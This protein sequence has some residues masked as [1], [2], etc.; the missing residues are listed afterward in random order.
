MLQ[1]TDE[2]TARQWHTKSISATVDTDVTI[3]DV[4]FSMFSMQRLYNQDQLDRSV[5]S[6][7]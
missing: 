1:L 5:N 7:F 3:D 2:V 6:D 4:V